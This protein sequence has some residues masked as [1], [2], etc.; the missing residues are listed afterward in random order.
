MR[1]R[2][3]FTTDHP[4]ILRKLNTPDRS[5][6]HSSILEGLEKAIGELGKARIDRRGVLV[7]TDRQDESHY[8]NADGFEIKFYVFGKD[9]ARDPAAKGDRPSLERG[10]VRPGRSRDLDLFLD[11][12]ANEL[13]NQY[14]LAYSTDAPTDGRVHNIRVTTTQGFAVEART[15][16]SW[17]D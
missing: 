6:G 1:L 11:R 4:A 8:T 12:V 5:L 7:I 2:Q 3:E 14:T 9:L 17:R 16:Y 10:D 13:R 15:G